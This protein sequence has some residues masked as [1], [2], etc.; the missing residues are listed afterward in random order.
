[1]LMDAASLP[2][3]V[4]ELKSLLLKT[5]NEKSDIEKKY[6]DEIGRLKREMDMFRLRFFAPRSEKMKIP[7]DQLELFN[8]AED[9]VSKAGK[10]EETE[11]VTYVRRKGRKP[12]E[13]DTGRYPSVDI[14]HDLP[15]TEKVHSCGQMMKEIGADVSY[16]LR[17]VPKQLLVERHIR[18]KYACPCQGTETDGIEGAVRIAE[19]PPQMIEKSIA[20]PSLLADILVSKFSDSLPFYR[21]EKILNR[22]GIEIS[23]ETLS[24]WTVKVHK[25]A[26]VLQDLMEEDLLGWTMMG[27]DETPVQVLGEKD[28]KNETKSFMWVMRG[29]PP[30]KPIVVFRY[31]QTRSGEFVRGYLKDWNGTLVC[32][33]Y[34]GY[35]SGGRGTGIR[36][37]GCWAHVR[38]KFVEAVKLSKGEG[39]ATEA[40]E[41]IREL[42]QVE[43]E[44]RKG[45]LDFDRIRELRQ[46]KSKPVLERF[47]AWLDRKA[48]EI[49]PTSPV[50]N[51][52]RYALGEWKKLTVF[53]DDGRVPVDNNMT[54]NAIRP[55]VVGK[56]NW[57]FS[58][59]PAGADASA[60]LYGLIETAKANGLEPYWYLNYLFE[61]FPLCKGEEDYRALLPYN[62]TPEKVATGLQVS[63][64]FTAYRIQQRD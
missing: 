18:K 2:D 55:F 58:A 48:S 44:A 37:A 1:M 59:C 31:R 3:S 57:L 21:Q 45:N 34:A 43:D 11:Q 60:F 30:G 7:T 46:S 8:E 20:T 62:L 53:L 15:E 5:L 39:C 41:Q 35:D 63:P 49:P 29:G 47:K 23:R 51:A 61:K 4:D 54:E 56:K 14:V 22:Y 24:R 26:E 52:I 6:L 9:T 36:L 12:R 27:M 19:I 40:V 16:K 25:K 42:Y 13:L 17:V 10:T 28:R 64:D 38:R 50:G 33:G 32:D